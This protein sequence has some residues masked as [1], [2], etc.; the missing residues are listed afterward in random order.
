MEYR[1]RRQKQL[2]APGPSAYADPQAIYE[3]VEDALKV[4]RKGMFKI[5]DMT[6]KTIEQGADE[7]I[8]HLSQLPDRS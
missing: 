5:I 7:I 4:F 1:A 2:G 3:E 6:D 8:R